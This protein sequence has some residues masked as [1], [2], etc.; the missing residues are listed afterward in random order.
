MYFTI[1]R[2]YGNFMSNKRIWF[3]WMESCLDTQSYGPNQDTGHWK[4]EGKYAREMAYA[5]A[6]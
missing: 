5:I 6:E 3:V 1:L 4:G 2:A